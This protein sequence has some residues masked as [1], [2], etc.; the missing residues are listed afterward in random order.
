M[1]NQEKAAQL[2]AAQQKKL[3]AE[4]NAWYVGEQLKEMVDGDEWAAGVLAQELEQNKAKGLDKAKAEIAAYARQHREGNTGCC[5]PKKAEE[6]L[7]KF[8]G[9]EKAESPAAPAA[10]NLIKLEDFF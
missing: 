3:K 9:I 10:D 7:R 2:I 1:K 5:P 8:Y 6:I 4:S